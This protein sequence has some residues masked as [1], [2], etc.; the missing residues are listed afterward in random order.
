MIAFQPEFRPPLPTVYGPKDYRDFRD[1]LQQ[2]DDILVKSGIE[3]RFIDR[4]I[5]SDEKLSESH[6]YQFL[7]SLTQR[8]LRYSILRALTGDSFRELAVRV[9]DSQLCQWF[10]HTSQIDAARPLSKSTIERF[11]KMFSSEEIETLI[12]DLG[13]CVADKKY[14]K[15]LLLREAAIKFDKVFSDTTCVKANIHFP[16]DWVLLRDGVRTLIKAIE[17]IRS[18]GIKL[19]ISEPSGFLRAM[20]KYCMEMTHLRKKRDSDKKRKVVLRKMKKLTATVEKHA[21]NYHRKLETNWQDTDLSEA[22]AQYIRQRMENVLDQLPRALKQAHERIIGGRK[23][24]NSDKILSLYE[25][26]IHVLLRGKANA[27]VEFG[28]ALHLVEQEDGLII[29]WKFIKEQ[30]KGDAALVKESIE[31]ITREYGQPSSYTADRGFDSPDNRIE[32]EKLVIFNAICPLSVPLLKERLQESDFCLYQKRRGSTEGRIGIFKNAYLGA[33]MRSKGFNNRR[34]RIEWCV[35][36][37]NLWKLA[38]M[39]LKQK[40]KIEDAKTA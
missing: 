37:H 5:S 22:E 8:A 13:R 4:H 21:I 18:H 16:V 39:A 33:P 2:I 34:T 3:A 24:K 30:P 19:R 9:S 7:V 31:R 36:A 20:N 14:A 38:D 25:P 27:E 40:E 26:D 1:H 35:L 15:E 11:E 23:I 12:H 32:L 29:H 6:S 28:N 17:L 10:T